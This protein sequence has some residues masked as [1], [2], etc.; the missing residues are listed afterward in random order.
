MQP[1]PQTTQIHDGELTRAND[2]TSANQATEVLPVT[3][4]DD[5]NHLS[6]LQRRSLFPDPLD[7]V[8]LG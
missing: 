3:I 4:Q 8:P 1:T 6:P 5:S 2:G 7:T